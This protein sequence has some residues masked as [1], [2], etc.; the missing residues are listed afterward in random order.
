MLKQ[1][2]AAG[3]L[4][5]AFP[6]QLAEIVLIILTIKLDNTITPSTPEEIKQTILAFITL[7]EKGTDAP[8]GALNYLTMA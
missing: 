1:G 2:I 4:S 5:F 6:E 3:D 8:A 7:V